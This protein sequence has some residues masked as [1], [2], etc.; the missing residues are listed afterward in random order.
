MGT[1]VGIW[2]R[3]AQGLDGAGLTSPGCYIGRLGRATFEIVLAWKIYWACPV[4][5]TH[6][7]VW[8]MSFDS[9]VGSVFE[10][11]MRRD[12]EQLLLFLWIHYDT[13]AGL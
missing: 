6:A 5:G 12:A 9:E 8:V 11:S 7:T 2:L 4:K 10:E 1:G 3:R 13:F